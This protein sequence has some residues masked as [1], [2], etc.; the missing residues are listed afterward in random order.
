MAEDRFS[1]PDHIIDLTIGSVN[2]RISAP[3]H[4]YD[5]TIGCDL[6]EQ[7]VPDEG[8][9]EWLSDGDLAHVEPAASRAY[10]GGAER[11]FTDIFGTDADNWSTAPFNAATD[12]GV[13]GLNAVNAPV[14]INSLLSDIT[15]GDRTI[16]IHFTAPAVTDGKILLG[17]LNVPDW[18]R[19][20]QLTWG[21]GVRDAGVGVLIVHDDGALDTEGENIVGIN[22]A[23][24][25]IST[26][27]NGSAAQTETPTSGMLGP[28]N[29]AGLQTFGAT[30]ITKIRVRPL[31]TAVELSALTSTA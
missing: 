9:P 17:L 10:A 13:D 25:A 18:D 1:T 7:Y 15:G 8:A 21:G 27:V 11:S 3:R 24:S 2:I 19:G 14:A 28:F 23:D 12:I 20:V 29:F 4:L 5:E 6:T 16:L 30:R 22:V 26:S 31:A